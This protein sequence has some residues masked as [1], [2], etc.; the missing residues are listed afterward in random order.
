MPISIWLA[1]A[2]LA[3]SLPIAWWSLQGP[4]RSQARR[5]R[6]NLASTTGQSSYRGAVLNRPASERVV[7]PLLTKLASIGRRFLPQEWFARV[8]DRL[9]KAGLLGRFRSEQVAGLKML[10][11]LVTTVLFG[12]VIAQDP[13]L[14]SVGGFVVMLAATWFVPDALISGRGDR[15]VQAIDKELPDIMDQLTVS[16]EAGLGFEAA[17][18]RIGEKGNGNLSY[19][20]ARAMQDIKLGM[21]RVEALQGLAERTGSSEVRHFVLALRQAEKMG[22]PLAKTLRIQSGEMRQK[23]RLRAEEAAYKLP[24]KLV[25]PL[26]LCILPAIFIVLLGPSVLQIMDAFP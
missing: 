17:I 11:A 15:R 21:S 14:L 7:D 1:A 8:D 3:S 10:L 20:F 12:A 9:A 23:R 26:G 19:E 13:T 2:A 25:F 4:D 5:T 24:V 6:S 18:A 16:V 22:V